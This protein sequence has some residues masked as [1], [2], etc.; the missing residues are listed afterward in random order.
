LARFER[1]RGLKRGCVVGF[2]RTFTCSSAF[3]GDD[4]GETATSAAGGLAEGALGAAPDAGRELGRERGTLA[5]TGG[6]GTRGDARPD[7][8]RVGVLRPLV[9]VEEPAWIPRADVRIDSLPV[10]AP[11]QRD[12]TCPRMWL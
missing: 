3:P 10:S 9:C 1:T 4:A 11:T 8:G 2:V 5:G 6:G 7:D 12:V